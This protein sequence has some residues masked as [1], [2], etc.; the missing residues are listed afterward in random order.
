M[1]GIVSGAATTAFRWRDLR[2]LG[3]LEGVV[4]DAPVLLVLHPDGLSLRC[5]DRRVDGRTLDLFRPPCGPPPLGPDE[6]LRDR[7]TGSG[8]DF[9][10]EAHSGALAGKSLRPIAC[11]KDDWFDWKLYHPRGQVAPAST[12]PSGAATP[13]AVASEAMPISNDAQAVTHSTA[14]RSLAPVRSYSQP[15]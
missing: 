4:G 13:C 10:G 8:W 12:S 14:P 3:S 2:A 5:F 15:W 7:E 11:L 1:V 9:S 6:L